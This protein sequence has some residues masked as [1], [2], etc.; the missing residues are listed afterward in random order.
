MN[1]R[2]SINWFSLVA[3]WVDYQVCCRWLTLACLAA[4]TWKLN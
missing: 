1:R 2:R 4:E 3:K